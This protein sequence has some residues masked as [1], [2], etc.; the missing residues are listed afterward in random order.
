MLKDLLENFKSVNTD[1]DAPS[2]TWFVSPV[3]GKLCPLELALNDGKRYKYFSRYPVVEGSVGIIGYSYPDYSCCT[4]QAGASTG[5]FGV[6]TD[7]A[8]AVA[9]KRSHAL[10]LDFVF[11]TDPTKTDIKR[12]I[13]YIGFGPDDYEKTLQFDKNIGLIRP[14]TYYIRRILAAASIIA[15]AKLCTPG[16]ADK[17]KAAILEKIILDSKMTKLYWGPPEDIGVD[18]RDIHVPDTDVE[19]F[20]DE[21]GNRLG[22]IS[23]WDEGLLKD[24]SGVLKQVI[25][26]E[27]ISAHVEKY[28]HFGAISIMV[29]GGFKN[30]L[31]AYLSVDPPIEPFYGEI[32]AKLKGL[33]SEETYRVL[34]AKRS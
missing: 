26:S 32:C 25:A 3:G 20:F 2:K 33:G 22:S 23:S 27:E 8:P 28:S 15:N 34:E 16:D 5:C 30:L 12:C 31:E 13:K 9:A 24:F 11:G 21:Y 10:E 18:F 4:P 14:I 6:I 1:N 19:A 29:R 7:A 17:A